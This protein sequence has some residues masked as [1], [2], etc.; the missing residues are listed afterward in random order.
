LGGRTAVWTVVDATVI[1]TTA[2][3]GTS[4]L[5]RL[6]GAAPDIMR[7]MAELWHTPGCAEPAADTVGEVTG[8]F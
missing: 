4:Q 3:T 5:S 7:R 2:A 1:P 6:G 8:F